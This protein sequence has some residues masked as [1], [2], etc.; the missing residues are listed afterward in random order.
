MAKQPVRHDLRLVPAAV[1]CWLTVS[2]A[3]TSTAI[4]ILVAAVSCIAA[5]ILILLAIPTV[6]RRLPQ[7]VALIQRTVLI[8]ALA[9]GITAIA[10]AVTANYQ[11]HEEDSLLATV[12][13]KQAQATITG[14]LTSDPIKT[15]VSADRPW[16]E[17]TWR[18]TL[19]IE[20]IESRGQSQRDNQRIAIIGPRDIEDLQAG[21]TIKTSGQL[22]PTDRG[23]NTRAIL[24]IRPNTTSANP[25]QGIYAW[26][27]GMREK[28]RAATSHLPGDPRGLIPSMVVGDTSVLPDTLDQAMRDTS[29]THLTAVSGANCT[30]I[31]AGTLMIIRP[32]Q[33]WRPRTRRALRVIAAL[34]VL[35]GYLIATGPQPS[36]LRASMMGAVGLYGILQGRRNTGIAALSIAVIGLLLI[37]PW[38]ARTAGFSLSVLSTAGIII[39]SQPAAN[40]LQRWGT[41][42]TLSIAL[43]VS[44]C[45]QIA[46]L[47]VLLNLDPRLTIYSL[48]ANVAASPLFPFVTIFGFLSLIAVLSI[49]A[50]AAPLIFTASIP[51]TAI[52]AIARW[53]SALPGAT[54]DWPPP[55][56]FWIALS[57]IGAVSA[58]LWWQRDALRSQRRLIITAI[59]VT[60][61]F[62]IAALTPQA[63]T[64]RS[65]LGIAPTQDWVAAQCDVGQ[66]DATIIRS[67]SIVMIDVGPPGD[68]AKTCLNELQITTIDTL[69]LSHWHLD[70]VG[71]LPGVLDA[72]TVENIII[73]PYDQP[74]ATAQPALEAIEQADIP[75]KIG[76]KKL[77]Q[78][79]HEPQHKENTQQ[80][81]IAD[82]EWNLLW[83]TQKTIQ[84]TP[85]GADDGTTV[86]DLSLVI[87]FTIHREQ[88]INIIALGDVE[89]Q[90]QR[91]L[92]NTWKQDLQSTHI[93]IVKVA[94]HGSA[95]QSQPLAQALNPDLALIGVGKDNDYGHP[96]PQALALYDTEHTLVGRTDDH[97]RIT[98]EMHVRHGLMIRTETGAV[99]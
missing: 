13:E 77:S 22:R 19:T 55:R 87:H 90:G 30:I 45:A 29:L 9:T 66:G 47:P 71:G 41:P 27:S 32:P 79:I 88:E 56:G 82:I 20:N 91:Q 98:I 72:T 7:T 54:V 92:L 57:T 96:S 15:T 52:A 62:A 50:L 85:P 42:R 48:P 39:G 6:R 69:F 70:H 89:T 74:T 95:R 1:T 97:G 78:E 67:D 11:H 14:Q 5:T 75:T 86:N 61:V 94:H 99:S 46:C 17:D 34:G 2:W 64:L 21:Q 40:A 43:A 93:D 23:E 63:Q 51:A 18:A 33:R 31:I 81:T 37:D 12:S 36:I 60:T 58:L 65:R 10:L 3:I 8:T 26:G 16:T 49:P 38:L 76:I 44:S 84:N 83:P 28:L 73:P 24:F 53:F 68:A 59:T 80:G 25:P 35:G 4:A